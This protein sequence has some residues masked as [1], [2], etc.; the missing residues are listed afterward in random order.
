MTE[1][2]VADQVPTTKK[3]VSLAETGKV[4]VRLTAAHKLL[5]A[6]RKRLVFH[7]IDDDE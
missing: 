2:Q 5:R 6:V 7:A 4:D 3:Y 1:Q